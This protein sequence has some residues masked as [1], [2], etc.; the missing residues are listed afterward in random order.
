[1]AKKPAAKSASSQRLAGNALFQALNGIPR[2]NKPVTKPSSTSDRGSYST[3]PASDRS[4]YSARPA[5][6]TRAPPLGQELR[7]RI[8]G[9][10]PKPTAPPKGPQEYQQQQQPQKQSAQQ[11]YKQTQSQQQPPQNTSSLAYR[12]TNPRPTSELPSTKYSK[13]GP[14][15]SAFATSNALKHP[16][17]AAKLSSSTPTGP[18][19]H[20]PKT[21]TRSRNK[22]VSSVDKAGK[23]REAGLSYQES[24]ERYADDRVRFSQDYSQSKQQQSPRPSAS[25]SHGSGSGSSRFSE[26]QPNATSHSTAPIPAPA[27]APVPAP[28]VA[29]VVVPQPF[30]STRTEPEASTGS[31]VTAVGDPV[32]SIKH[33][34]LPPIVQI[35]NLDRGTT[36]ED[37]H[38]FFVELGEILDCRVQTLG[39]QGSMGE[40][41]FADS[42][43][44]KTALTKFNGALADGRRLVVNIVKYNSIAETKPNPVD[45][46]HH[47]WPGAA[48][49]RSDNYLR[50]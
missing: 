4:S 30:T 41:T 17:R 27:P 26:P 2:S 7:D 46:V 25:V 48:P 21:R 20:S 23:P 29:P 1:M 12:F 14:Q 33:S 45:N 6:S 42:G 8:N 15:G 19:S 35:S 9:K 28:F 13:S 36:R 16:G 24:R 11:N 18:S 5:P 38:K 32:Y 3:R 22:T 47:Q 34:A 31:R 43:A 39:T 44:A 49:L 10:T 37:L 40:I 50:R